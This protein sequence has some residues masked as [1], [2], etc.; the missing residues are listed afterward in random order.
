VLPHRWRDQIG[1]ILAVGLAVEEGAGRRLGGEGK[2]GHG[3]HDEVDPEELD[4]LEGR[5]AASVRDRTDKSQRDSDKVDRELELQKLADRVVHI[6]TCKRNLKVL[7]TFFFPTIEK[8]TPHDGLD[9]GRKVVVHKDNVGGFLG[10]FSARDAHAEADVCELERGAV[11]CSIA[12][13]GHDLAL[14]LE[15]FNQ[16]LLV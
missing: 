15:A 16:D 10:D 4:R 2:G 5:L 3:I 12:G 8:L 11:V 13:H 6:A 7:F 14:L 9:D 1:A